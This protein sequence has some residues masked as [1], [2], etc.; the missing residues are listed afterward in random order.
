[1]MQ[2]T[3]ALFVLFA[4]SGIV[5]AAPGSSPT[6]YGQ[7]KKFQYSS[8]CSAVYA[9]KT[10]TSIYPYTTT[11]ETTVYKPSTYT[12]TE[13]STF[14]ETTTKTKVITVESTKTETK[15]IPYKSES[16]TTI[17]QTKPVWIWTYSTSEY[18]T[19]ISYP[20]TSTKVKT[21]EQSTEVFKT[22]TTETPCPEST[23]SVGTSTVV[24]TLLQ[25]AFANAIHHVVRQSLKF[26]LKLKQAFANAIYHVVRLKF[27]LKLKQAFANAIYHIVRL[28]LK[29]KLKQAFANAIHHIVRLK[30]KLKLKQAF[31]NAIHHVF[32][33]KLKQQHAYSHQIYYVFFIIQLFQLDC[34]G[35]KKC[36]MMR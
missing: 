12:R 6:S 27:K 30:L 3:A 11:I 16:F 29:L 23:V 36:G 32:R 22:Y 19:T 2:F 1:M 4:S 25:Q 20:V 9:T 18:E 17:C 21:Y 7:C 15:K 35:L 10:Q 26:K 33:L 13:E 5:A 14:Y 28:K 34:Q 31:A 24:K 8:T